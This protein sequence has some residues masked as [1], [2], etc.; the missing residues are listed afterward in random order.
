MVEKDTLIYAKTLQ[1]LEFSTEKSKRSF[2]YTEMLKK[3]ICQRKR[4]NVQEE[5]NQPYRIRP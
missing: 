4:E 3:I 5:E 1:N 2:T